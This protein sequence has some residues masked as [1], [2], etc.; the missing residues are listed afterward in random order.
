MIYLLIALGGAAGSVSRYWLSTAIDTRTASAFP[1][2]T[3][4]VNVIGSVLI[5][6]LA[7]LTIGD[8]FIGSPQLRFFLMT[9]FCGGYTTFSSFSLQTLT[10]MK[11]GEWPMAAAYIIGSVLICLVGVWL[12]HAAAGLWQRPPLA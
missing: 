5:G 12:G 9:G 2:G 7:N 10:L 6:F 1:W 3:L 11:D 8:R 4:A